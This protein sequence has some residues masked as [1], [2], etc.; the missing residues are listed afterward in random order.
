MAVCSSCGEVV[1]RIRE[2]NGV[3]LGVFTF[4]PLCD[5]GLHDVR[6]TAAP[7]EGGKALSVQ[8]T[9]PSLEDLRTGGGRGLVALGSVARSSGAGRQH[10]GRVLEV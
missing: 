3:P 4:D 1:V 2:R 5:E 9:R 7:G 6:G 8:V 10:D